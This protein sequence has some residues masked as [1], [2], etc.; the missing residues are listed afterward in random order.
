[1]I[2][3]VAV[4][5]AACAL[6]PAAAIVSPPVPEAATRQAPAGPGADLTVSLDWLRQRL[7]SRGGEAVAV[8]AVDRDREA[9]A[10]AHIPTARFLGHEATLDHNGHRL[11]NPPEL[12]AALARAGATDE[13]RIV[14]Y[15]DDAMSLGWL[16][17]A[18]ASIGHADHTSVLDGN[19]L[20]W[21]AAGHPVATGAS[22]AGTGRLTVRAATDVAV[23]R[24]WVRRHLDD[25]ATRLLD[26]RS[27]REWRDGTIPNATPLLWQDF[28]ADVKLGR[29]KTPAGIREVFEKAGVRSGQTAV[30]YCAIGMRASLA[31]FAA[32][33]VGIPAKVYV[34]SW[35]DWTADP[36][37]PVKR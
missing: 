17:M 1:M 6:A 4:I 28:F 33:A 19:V 35:A 23:D 18:L 29:F 20:A 21:Q 9:F 13:S 16:Y 12:A 32:R 22:P 27:P 15:G 3:K 36:S 31:Y 37:N 26:V 24:A 11:L 34:G 2:Y 10:R 8:I 14:L 5:C 30:T 25:T 7:D